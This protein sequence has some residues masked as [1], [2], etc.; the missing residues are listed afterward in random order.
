KFSALNTG[1][2]LDLQCNITGPGEFKEILRL[3][4][5]DLLLQKTTKVPKKS[6]QGQILVKTQGDG[7]GTLNVELKY[8]EISQDQSEVC[9]FDIVITATRVNRQRDQQQRQ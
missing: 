2:E 5:E 4:N 8:N 9:P 7:I 3:G 1:G 6:I